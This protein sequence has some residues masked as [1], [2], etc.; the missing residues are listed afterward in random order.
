[1]RSRKKTYVWSGAIILGVF[2]LISMINVCRA[3]RN[4]KIDFQRINDSAKPGTIAQGN[5]VVLCEENSVL[6]FPFLTGGRL[7]LFSVSDGKKYL[8]ERNAKF[9][10]GM[11]NPMIQGE[12]IYWFDT[13]DGSNQGSFHAKS[14]ADK[15]KEFRTP[16]Y[17]YTDYYAVA[18]DM[19]YYASD[20]QIIQRNL[21]TGKES[22]AGEG[23]VHFLTIEGSILYRYDQRKKELICREISSEKETV[24]HL[25]FDKK[26]RI[27]DLKV[28]QKDKLLIQTARRGIWEYQIATGAFRK[29]ADNAAI[30]NGNN[31]GATGNSQML[32]IKGNRLFYCDA[33][34]NVY[35]QNLQTGKVRKRIDWRTVAEAFQMDTE[36]SA[37]LTM[38]LSWCEDYIV[39]QVG[40]YKE[41][42]NEWKAGIL[43]FDYVGKEVYKEANLNLVL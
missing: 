36:D 42:K 28:Y 32:H 8:I 17:L 39:F 18:Q 26:V 25:P 16:E 9:L 40:C 21:L 23:S 6:D 30:L 31:R 1:M 12:T 22:V 7:C 3:E 20:R 24:I 15:R 37:D 34:S 43:V 41:E 4:I 10:Q 2:F 33:E 11:S 19:L 27:L 35:E 29:I 14:I 5:Y 38:L 13:W